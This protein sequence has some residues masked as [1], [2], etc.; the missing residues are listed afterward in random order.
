MDTFQLAKEIPVTFLL[1]LVLQILGFV[2]WLVRLG[3]RTKQI[4]KDL[5]V[6]SRTMD[7]FP[8]QIPPPEVIERL[9][10]I[11]ANQAFIISSLRMIA[12][13]C[14]IALMPTPS[15]EI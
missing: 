1:L 5:H 13:K 8:K 11:E 7:A 15:D 12:S 2:I 9:T 6:L 10:K 4:E 14:D 3:D